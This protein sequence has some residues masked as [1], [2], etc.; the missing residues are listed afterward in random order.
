MATTK[1]RWTIEEDQYL[2]DH[3]KN[4]SHNLQKGF[5][6]L[7]GITLGEYIRNRKLTKAAHD[8]MTSDE[9]IKGGDESEKI[10]RNNY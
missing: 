9:T 4:Y 10:K 2:I 6:M 1:K 7:C 3:L 5:S 8:L